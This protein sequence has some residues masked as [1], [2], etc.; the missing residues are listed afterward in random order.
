MMGRARYYTLECDGSQVDP[1]VGR[2]M[3]RDTW[4]LNYNNPVELNRYVYAA[5]N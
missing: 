4:P 5:A 1:G 3:S 2:F